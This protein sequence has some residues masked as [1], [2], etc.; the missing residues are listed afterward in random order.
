MSYV[1]FDKLKG[2]LAQRPGVKNP[3][4][5]AAYIGAKKYGA[6]AMHKAAGKGTSLRGHKP[7]N[8]K[9]HA[10]IERFAKHHGG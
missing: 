1:G 10:M 5:L 9:R 8:A 2:E 6:G 4:A 7:V 3:A